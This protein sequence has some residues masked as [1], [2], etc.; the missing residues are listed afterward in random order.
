MRLMCASVVVALLMAAIPVRVAAAV[1]G[2][3]PST[4]IAAS[5]GT[6]QY[7]STAMTESGA[8]P[9][10]CG[11]FEDFTNTMWFSW[12]A[13]QSTVTM[14]DI[15]SFVS[16]GSTDFLAI[17]F[18]YAQKNGQLTLVGC[19]AYPATVFFGASAG[20]T[21]LILSA[22]LGADDTG[23][24]ELSDHGGTFDLTIQPIRGRVLSDRFH[25]ADS[26]VDEGLS[27]ECGFEVT[28][29]F[30]DRGMSKTFLTT[31]GVRMF[32]FM[33]VGSTTFSTA[34]ASLTLSYAQPF[35]DTLD[36]NVT[37]LGLPVKVVLNGELV[38]LDAG[39]LVLG[40]DGVVFEAGP[41]SVFDSGVDIC[42]LLTA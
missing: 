28:V 10:S 35:R 13:T 16:D 21:Y 31:S 11:E 22:A 18:V 24:P 14:V 32:T 33:I 15:N 2:D 38:T 9:K 5:V 3:E 30:D 37:I 41:H 23:E 8:D 6:A 20:T 34:D 19:S 39:R 1:S 7:N 4:A 40:P 17:L 36:G 29:S 12:T 25:E 27:E 42:A 26:F